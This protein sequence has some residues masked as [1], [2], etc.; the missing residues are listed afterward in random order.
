MKNVVLKK[1]PALGNVNAAH[2]AYIK[3]VEGRTIGTCMDTPN[4]AAFA[5]SINEKAHTI[6][7]PFNGT[8]TRADVEGRLF[9]L[10]ENYHKKYIKYY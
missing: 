1:L 2:Y 8:W 10:D 5:F 3:N 7:T 4:N 6:D 9:G